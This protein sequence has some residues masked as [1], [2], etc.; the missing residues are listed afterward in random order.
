MPQAT[1]AIRILVDADAC[2]VKDEVVRVAERHGLAAIFVSNAWMRLPTSAVV[3][4]RLVAEGPDAAD[5]WIAGEIG[6]ADICVTQ[7]IPLAGRCLKAGAR[8]LSPTGRPFTPAN[9]GMALAVR[10][11]KSHLR[12]TGDMRG[13]PAAFARADRSRFLQALE[14]AVQDIRRGR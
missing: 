12:E 3:E 10:D 6:A 9:I 4:R 13:G 7:D 2:P 5:D 11:L 14:Q 8:A 1:P